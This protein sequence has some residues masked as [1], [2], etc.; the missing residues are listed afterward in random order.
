MT[1]GGKYMAPADGHALTD[2]AYWAPR[3]PVRHVGDLQCAYVRLQA[4][5]DHA[6]VEGCG[7]C[8]RQLG[9]APVGERAEPTSGRIRFVDDADAVGVDESRSFYEVCN[10]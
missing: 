9:N 6:L 3:E 8:A 4:D 7:L 10:S 2:D 5:P 1:G